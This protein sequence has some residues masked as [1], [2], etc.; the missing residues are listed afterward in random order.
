VANLKAKKKPPPRAASDG[1]LGGLCAPL[2]RGDSARAS[3]R[4]NNSGAVTTPGQKIKTTG[5]E[6][7]E[8][9]EAPEA[10][11]GTTGAQRRESRE[12]PGARRGTTG[13]QRRESREAPGARR[14]TTGLELR[15][16]ARVREKLT[17]L[18]LL[19]N[20]CPRNGRGLGCAVG[21]APDQAPDQKGCRRKST[22]SFSDSIACTRWPPRDCHQES[23]SN[24]EKRA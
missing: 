3:G 14:G 19:M 5:A 21:Q 23:G 8:S 2:R 24:S 13:A 22:S 17:R 1:A 4:V 11:R 6:R 12:A 20:C 9:R 15:L 16:D 10:R 7:R 18:S